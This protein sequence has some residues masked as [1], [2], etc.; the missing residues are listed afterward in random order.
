MNADTT[1]V[2][3]KVLKSGLEFAIEQLGNRTPAA[4]D[5]ADDAL[6]VLLEGL[7]GEVSAELVAQELLNLQ[8]GLKANDTAADK[9]LAE[10]FGVVDE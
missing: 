5:A 2:I 6:R 1:D 7:N 4:L 9:A 3:L 8:D 10:K